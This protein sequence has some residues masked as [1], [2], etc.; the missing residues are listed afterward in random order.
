MMMLL[1]GGEREREKRPV[2]GGE[3]MSSILDML[4]SMK[5]SDAAGYTSLELKEGSGLEIYILASHLSI[6]MKD[7]LGRITEGK[8]KRACEHQY[9]LIG[10]VKMSLQVRL[11]RKCK[12]TKE[13]RE[14]GILETTGRKYFK[15]EGWLMA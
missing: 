2:W 7:R 1:T 11:N 3:V 10:V 14:C 4:I 15:Q 6:E 12:K 9:L 13:T 5:R 8:C